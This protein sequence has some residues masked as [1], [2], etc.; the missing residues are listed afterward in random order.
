[1][2]APSLPTF[3][4]DSPRIAPR[5][6][7]KAVD[8]IWAISSDVVLCPK[9]DD[10]AEKVGGGKRQCIS[11]YH[12][13][14]PKTAA[15][16]CK[17]PGC[18]NRATSDVTPSQVQDTPA[19][20][21]DN[22]NGPKTAYRPSEG[23][24]SPFT[25]EDNKRLD[26]EYGTTK[27]SPL[28]SINRF[29]DEYAAE[30]GGKPRKPGVFGSRH[31]AIDN[32]DAI[33]HSPE[34][35]AV[36]PQIRSLTS[37][38]L[39]AQIESRGGEDG[40]SSSDINHTVFG[41]A[42]RH[43]NGSHLDVAGLANDIHEEL[44]GYGHGGFY[45]SKTVTGKGKVVKVRGGHGAR[46]NDCRLQD[47]GPMTHSLA[48]DIIAAHNQMHHSASKTA[49]GYPNDRF[50]HLCS[51]TGD[52][53]ASWGGCRQCFLEN[54]PLSDSGFVKGH[55]AVMSRTSATVIT[56]EEMGRPLYD[57]E[58]GNWESI[59]DRIDQREE[60]DRRKVDRGTPDRRGEPTLRT[61]EH[62]KR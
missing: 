10:V 29:P 19:G 11:C 24:Y 23:D 8:Q 27:D 60:E 62:P 50:E 44:N 26:D 12:T 30:H 40:I 14:Q 47:M 21:C 39:S 6:G 2:S 49:V 20:Y 59:F 46:C 54:A 1:M 35:D 56:E 45:G 18:N 37:Q 34:L 55:D 58:T 4:W 7:A 15:T 33:M 17:Y 25:Y 48:V 51:G 22:H 36:W 3:T 31:V 28:H 42:Q 16:T 5:L 43:W 53:P 32:W 9:C 57:D 61:W 13:F 41:Y 38:L 52:T